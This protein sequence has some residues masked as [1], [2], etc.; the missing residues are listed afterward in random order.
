MPREAPGNGYYVERSKHDAKETW[1]DWFP[2]AD[3]ALTLDDVIEGLR[4]RGVEDVT[5][6]QIRF[7]QRE[8]VIPSP[9]RRK[10]DK[11]ASRARALYPPHAI[12]VI[13]V[14]R[15]M[16]HNGAGLR[17][18]G[19]ELAKQFNASADLPDHERLSMDILDVL[20][21]WHAASKSHDPAMT[22]A[23]KSA[24]ER[25]AQRRGVPIRDVSV[26]F[27]DTE[28]Q[29]ATYVFRLDTGDQEDSG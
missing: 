10:P 15:D 25:E 19:G 5:A 11:A 24:A 16:Q 27:T 28:G 23:I 18:I 3:P 9:I 14:V 4:D 29:T 22:T 1:L 13:R 7:W 26:T 21:S 8:R 17:F 6:D 12:G 2:D 20:S